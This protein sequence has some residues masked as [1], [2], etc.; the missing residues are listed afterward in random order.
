MTA[1]T[2]SH[3]TANAT[4]RRPGDADQPAE[5][6]R[7]ALAA[8]ELEPDRIHM[9][10]DRPRGRSKLR[11]RPEQ[12]SRGDDGERRLQGVE[13]ERRRGE[14]PPS[15]AQHVGR[16][17]VARADRSEIAGAGEL[18]SGSARTGSIRGDSRAPAPAPPHTKSR[19]FCPMRSGDVRWPKPIRARRDRQPAS[20]L[21]GP[22]AAP[23]RR[24]CCGSANGAP[25]DR[26]HKARRDRSGS[27]P[28]ARRR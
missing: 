10:K 6:G 12:P 20:A 15:G 4:S 23:R 13:R 28:P 7:D 19:P 25:P 14:P 16:A 22:R 26:A 3:A 11:L 8:A 1:A 17:D 9:A 21:P 27:R 2:A 24:V 18:A 5:K